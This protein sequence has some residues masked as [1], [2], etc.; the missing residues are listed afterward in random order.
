MISN[1]PVILFIG[2]LQIP[3]A[4]GESLTKEFPLHRLTDFFLP[5][6]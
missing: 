1:N 3:I 6:V 2:E 4:N 5:H